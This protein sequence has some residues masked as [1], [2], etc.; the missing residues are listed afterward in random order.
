MVRYYIISPHV[1]PEVLAGPFFTV[2]AAQA[3]LDEHFIDECGYTSCS[4]RV[5]EDDTD[6]SDIT[7]SVCGG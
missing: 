4:I 6:Y 5:E 3:H 2:E 1:H 7:R